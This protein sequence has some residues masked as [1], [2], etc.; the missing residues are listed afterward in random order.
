VLYH[1]TSPSIAVHQQNSSAKI[2]IENA[3]IIK[4]NIRSEC[5]Y[6]SA[7]DLL[8]GKKAGR[9]YPADDLLAVK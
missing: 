8:A 4:R 7:A 3:K 1:A 5:F 2:I 9:N 6:A